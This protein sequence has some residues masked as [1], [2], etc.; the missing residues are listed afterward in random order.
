MF[1]IRDESV[2][3]KS[4]NMLN[5]ILFGDKTHS[6]PVEGS[7]TMRVVETFDLVLEK[8]VTD[9]SIKKFNYKGK[10]YDVKDGYF[11]IEVIPKTPEISPFSVI[12]ENQLALMEAVATQYEENL[13]N[14]I[15]DMEV[16]ATIYET[17]LEIQGGL[18]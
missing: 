4:E 17:L 8:Y 13:E 2:Y 9:I 12:E 18:V 11:E 7:T 14:R 16:Q 15:N 5:W 3:Y 1:E 10:I 6:Q